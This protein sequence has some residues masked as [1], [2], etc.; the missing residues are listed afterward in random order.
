MFVDELEIK[1]KA[2]DGGDGVVRWLRLKYQPKAGPAG[3]NGGKGGDV[4]VR[5]VRNQA[6]LAKYTGAKEFAARSGEDGRSQSQ[7]GRGSNDLYIDVPVGSRVTNL[8][9]GREYFIDEVGQTEMIL[10]GGAGGLGNEHFKSS[11]NRTPQEST[12]GKPGERGHFRIELLLSADVGFIGKP[13]AGKSTLLNS[14]TNASSAV[15]AYP[16][17]TLEPHLGALFEFTL[18]DIPGLIEGAAEGK[19]LGHK[20]L[21]H[22]ERT[23]MLVHLVSLE[24]DY[25]VD[26]YRAIRHELEAF[27]KALAT[28]EE[29]VVLTKSDL[30]TSEHIRAVQK[31]IDSYS[32]RVF[33]ISHN[34]VESIKHFRDELVKYLRDEK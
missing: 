12:K 14:L 33:V 1:A 13:N 21:R 7:H 6:L 20:F 4:F 25:P 32:N 28:K 26:T 8:Q 5:G 19:G 9:N 10:A 27:D 15:G 24:D 3:G 30:A 17:T 16:F 31:T 29:W 23:R 18:A 34:S 11:I 22:V 2:G